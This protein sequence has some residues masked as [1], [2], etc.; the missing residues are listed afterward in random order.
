MQIF[1]SLYFGV[2]RKWVVEI[3]LVLILGATTFKL[4]FGTFPLVGKYFFLIEIGSDFEIA[5]N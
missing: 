3:G 5:Q 2:S 4:D 1:D